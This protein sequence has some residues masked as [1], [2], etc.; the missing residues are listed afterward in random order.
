MTS[1]MNRAV[2]A[3]H[4]RFDALPRKCK[5]IENSGNGVAEWVPL[6]GVVVCKGETDQTFRSMMLYLG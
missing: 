5:P 4:D 3:I 1:Q 2:Q 6:S